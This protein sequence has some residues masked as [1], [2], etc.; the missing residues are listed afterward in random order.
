MNRKRFATL[1]FVALM[2]MMTILLVCGAAAAQ[3]AKVEGFITGRSGSDMTLQTSDVPKLVVVLTDSTSVA[4]VQGVLKARRKQM[5]MA[6]LTP[7]LKVKVEGT[8]D[9]QNQLVATKVTFK[10]N[11]LED[12]QAIQA[13]VQPAQAQI[14]QTRQEL[15]QQK[16]AL[17]QQQLAL[18]QQAMKQ[19]QQNAEAQAKIDANKAAIEEAN[20]R[21]GQLD[22]FNILD[23]VVVYF[24]N[25]KITIDPQY[26]PQLMALVQKANGI[27]GYM[28]Q[29]KGYASSTGSMAFN[30]RLSDDRA[31]NVTQFLLQQGHIPLTRMLAPGAMGESRQVGND[32]TAE[33]QAQNR[34]VVVRI[35]QNKGI[36]GT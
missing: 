2:S 13:G 4:Q 35:L 1:G 30:Q 23:E 20:K 3:T 6:A 16:L 24:G 32:K 11:D 21:F 8:Y 26:K 31:N 10:G 19:E 29:V 28:I 7:G 12:A 34:R 33:G 14:Q 9:A 17:E 27:N 15:D 18:Q 25:G 36:A 5:S 22:D